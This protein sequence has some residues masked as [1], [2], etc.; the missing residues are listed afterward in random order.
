MAA[1][2]P[3]Q[4]DVYASLPLNVALGPDLF[5]ESTN[6]RSVHCL[7]LP[8]GKLNALQFSQRLAYK[9]IRYA[10]GVVVGAEGHL[11]TSPDSL[12]V[13]DYNAVLPAES[14]VLHY[15]TT[16]EERRRMFPVDPNIERT[17]VTS[18]V[19]TNRR[20]QFRTEIS[21]RDG[22]HCILTGFGEMYCDAVHF[23]PHSKGDMYISTYTQHRSRDHT[24]SDIIQEIDSIRNG[25]FLNSSAHRALGKDLAFLMTP[26]FA[27]NTNDIDPTAPP[28]EKRCTSHVFGDDESLPISSL[29]PGFRIRIHDTPAY[30]P[31]ILFDAVYACAVLHHFGTQSL[32]DSVTATWKDTFYPGGVVTVAQAE[33]KGITDERATIAERK[34]NQDLERDTRHETRHRPDTFD[35]LLTLPYAMVPRDELQAVLKEAKEKAEAAEQKHVQEK[36]DAWMRQITAV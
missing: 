31:A 4:I 26:N 27:M 16:N 12:N 22:K 15:N 6:W 34:Q 9:W 33:Y 24:R 19:H 32:K 2:P 14:I 36:V 17:D 30:P 10:I 25:L 23:L 29:C 3:P 35:M 28:R 13:V 11:S 7:T 18:S 5:L 21:E 8:L 20:D 1:A